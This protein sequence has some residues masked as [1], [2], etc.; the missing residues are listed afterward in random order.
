MTQK[1]LFEL[2]EL[3]QK[4]IIITRVIRAQT[5]FLT[6]VELRTQQMNLSGMTLKSLKMT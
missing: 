1:S 5:D 3:T 4:K 6:S 2:T